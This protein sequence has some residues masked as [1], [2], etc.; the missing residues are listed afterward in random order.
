MFNKIYYMVIYLRVV[1]SMYKPPIDV[2]C[3]IYYNAQLISLYN[4]LYN[5][6][7]VLD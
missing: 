2:F 3:L 1:Y 4:R 5:K 6:S 7:Y